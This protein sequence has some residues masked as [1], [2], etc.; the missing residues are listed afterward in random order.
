MALKIMGHG[1]RHVTDQE[2]MNTATPAATKT[3]FPFPH[4]LLLKETEKLIDQI[5]YEIL[6]S[7]HALGKEDQTYFGQYR[8]KSHIN[9]TEEWSPMLGIRN[10]H[11]KT[12]SLGLVAG[13]QTTVC[14][15]L[16]FLGDF[17]F[18]RKHTRNAFSDALDGMASTFGRLPAIDE[19]V[20][21]RIEAFKEVPVND[22]R[23]VSKFILEAANRNLIAPNVTVGVW[24]E[25]T[26]PTYADFKTRN[27]WSL[28]NSFTTVQGGK[29]YSPFKIATDTLKLNEY[30]NEVFGEQLVTDA[31][32]D[33]EHEDTEE[34]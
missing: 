1:I 7:A 33:L 16:L 14:S 5:G 32:P 20:G 34:Y 8:L 25:W 11:D 15:N 23:D 17:K 10:A 30:I 6:E 3:H 31:M 2:V 13:K 18:T 24:K 21:K 27:L 12:M 22:D 26:A 4:G 29:N 9:A 28:V 19:Y